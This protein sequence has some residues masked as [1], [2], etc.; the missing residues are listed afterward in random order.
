MS[1]ATVM[2]LKYWDLGKTRR[3]KSRV[4]S[5]KELTVSLKWHRAEWELEPYTRQQQKLPGE[6][7]TCLLRGEPR[8]PRE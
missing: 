3:V 5:F 7:G 1:W 6:R 2:V 8:E 4:S